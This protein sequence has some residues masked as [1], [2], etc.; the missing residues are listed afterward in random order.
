MAHDSNID[1]RIVE[2]M[3]ACR[4]G[5][6]DVADPAMEAL[7]QRMSDSPEVAKTY[8]RLQRLDQVLADAFRDVPVPA[9][10]QERILARLAACGSPGVSAVDFRQEPAGVSGGGIAA[11]RA[12]PRRWL[13]AA[14]GLAAA[15]AVVLG[16]FLH[17]RHS[18]TI[19]RSDLLTSAIE[20]SINAPRDGGNPMA[21][22]IQPPREFPFSQA[23]AAIFSPG[24]S[25]FSGMR[26]R[27]VRSFLNRDAVA[28]DLVGPRG[29]S[30]TV[31]V[32]T[33]SVEGLSAEVPL[34]PMLSTG[35]SSASAWQ[36]G[37]LVYV[38][39]VDGGIQDYE[40]FF[41]AAGG[42]LT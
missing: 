30:A 41:A 23:L 16:V 42:P 37:D 18:D 10:L 1:P 26:W 7:R 9:G 20:H 35:Q 39:V 36:E 12:W 24:E 14:G 11:R 25:L 15:A 6:Q 31:Y 17:F 27:V 13:I 2:A 32:S 29:V 33:C 4:P 19:R 5:S 28:Y 38:L 21:G 8:Q 3:E 34:R 40:R 22:P